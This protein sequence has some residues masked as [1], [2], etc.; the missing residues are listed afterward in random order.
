MHDI[1]KIRDVMDK[2]IARVDKLKQLT[3]ME[4]KFAIWEELVKQNEIELDDMEKELQE[5]RDG[6]EG[7]VEAQM[8]N[9]LKRGQQFCD[10]ID[11]ILGKK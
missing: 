10:L 5:E 7:I 9:E 4:M 11:S 8:R 1:E 6:S 3:C 2:Y